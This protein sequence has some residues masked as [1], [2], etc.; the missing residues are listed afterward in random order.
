MLNSFV[1]PHIIKFF[2]HE[3]TRR[4]LVLIMELV[5]SGDLSACLATGRA[6]PE[7]K[8][9]R[10]A[11]QI[12]SALE[13]LHS[14]NITHRD[15]KPENILIESEEPLNVKLSDFGLSKQIT[16][17]DAY[18]QTFCGTILYCAPEIYPGYD[19]YKSG[20]AGKRR[21]LPTDP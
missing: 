19:Q 5:P 15:I 20:K 1:Q 17:N 6:V 13:Y 2:H 18:L 10:I 12:C 21:R 8:C 4:N 7:F 3:E 11:W 14:R 9:Q 16:N